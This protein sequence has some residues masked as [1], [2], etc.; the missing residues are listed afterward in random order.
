VLERL[1]TCQSQLGYYFRNPSLLELALTHSSVRSDPDASNERLE[2]LGDAVIGLI[3]SEYLCKTLPG[4][5]EGELTKIKSVVVSAQTLA[6]FSRRL[7]LQESLQVGRGLFEK[8]LLPRSLLAN[9]YEAT[10]AAIFLDGGLDSAREFV[11]R[12]LKYEI[13]LV[14]RNEHRMNYKSILQHHVQK[15]MGATPHYRVQKEVGPN[16]GR[17]FQVVVV[18][19]QKEYESGWGQSKKDAEQQAAEKTFNILFPNADSSE[20]SLNDS[21]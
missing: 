20:I 12:Q 10:V 6:K 19:G 4:V 14:C 9:A 8:R 13:D 18:I 15:H 1:A 2:F 11:L 17:Q 3:A 16:H 7:N 21:Q 5:S